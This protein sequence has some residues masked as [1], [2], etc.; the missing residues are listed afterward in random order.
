MLPTTFPRRAIAAL[1][2]TAAASS[3][4]RPM[5]AQPPH[6][7]VELF[8]PPELP[9]CDFVDLT[10]IAP[11]AA[12]QLATLGLSIGLGSPW[13]FTP[14]LPGSMTG[15]YEAMDALGPFGGPSTIDL[16]GLALDI[17][18]FDTGFPFTLDAGGSGFLRLAV[19]PP[20]DVD[21]RSFSATFRIRDVSG[22]EYTGTVT[23]GTVP[24]PASV[25]LVAAG[26]AA[27]GL[28]ARRRQRAPVRTNG[29][30]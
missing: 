3:A 28:T 30:Q 17:N 10:I 8:C 23:P 15:F 13:R 29:A 22:A 2:L 6:I 21:P 24:E 27:L 16:S 25:A 19:D 7:D 1:L 20:P 5:D 14:L 4:P 12:V 9:G 11:S 18:F 26:L